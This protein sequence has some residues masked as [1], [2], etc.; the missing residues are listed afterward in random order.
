VADE[1]ITGFGRTGD[2]FA[3]GLYNLKPDIVTL[4][5]GITSAYFPLSASVISEKMWNVL[6]DASPEIGP[7]M[8]GF[9]YSGHPVGGAVAMA[10]I[11][12]MER[13][14]LIE[15]SAAMGV[16]FKQ[17]LR[18]RFAD[19]PY[20]GDIRGEGLMMA[21]ELVADRKA[22]RFFDPDKWVHRIIQRKALD[23]GVMVR[24]LPYVEAISFSPPL[25]IAPAE[26]DEALDRFQRG[27]DA[28]MPELRAAV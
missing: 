1:V 24:A 23:E 15:N 16:Y 5:K 21:I 2:W 25:C 19:H 6:R 8:H 11:D 4:A 27:F 22:K 7:V 18:E 17:R 26:I 20:V 9:T 14:N 3:T 28:A 13:E 12:I 10:N